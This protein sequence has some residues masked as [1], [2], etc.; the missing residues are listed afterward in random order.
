MDSG[1]ERETAEI[2]LQ[3]LTY[4]AKPDALGAVVQLEKPLFD[5]ASSPGEYCRPDF[6]LWLPNRKRVLVESMG[7]KTDEYLAS[8]ATSHP[9]MRALA[10]VVDLVEHHPGD[11][12]FEF[13]KR[14]TGAVRKG[15]R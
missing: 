5:E 7:M 12:P 10:G 14:L 15:M 3:Q 11:D 4:W 8:K 13:A 2:L 1:F 6:V 9:R